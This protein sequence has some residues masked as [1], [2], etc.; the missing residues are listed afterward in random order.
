MLSNKDNL[1]MA[2]VGHIVPS[3]HSVKINNTIR[4][5]ALMGSNKATIM[6][7]I[8]QPKSSYFDGPKSISLT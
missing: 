3:A 6:G 7:G 1:S 5:P 4:D 8:A 2:F